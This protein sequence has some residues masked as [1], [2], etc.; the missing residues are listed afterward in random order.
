MTG[1]AG[2]CCY[3]LPTDTMWE[4]LSAASAIKGELLVGCY[5]TVAAIQFPISSHLVP[6]R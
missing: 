3:S 4:D 5:L 2:Y 6:R 1:A